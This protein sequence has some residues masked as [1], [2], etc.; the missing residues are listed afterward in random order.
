MRLWLGLDALQGIL[1]VEQH[2]SGNRWRKSTSGQILML[3]RLFGE[4]D[5][6]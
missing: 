5:R 2:S 6:A 4:I 1:P 3:H